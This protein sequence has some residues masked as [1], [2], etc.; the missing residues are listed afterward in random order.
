ML[1]EQTGATMRRFTL[2]PTPSLI[3]HTAFRRRAASALMVTLCLTMLVSVGVLLMARTFV[4]QNRLNMRRRELWRAFNHAEAGIASIQHWA[5]NPND[6]TLD[7][8]LF[9]VDQGGVEGAEGTGLI[10]ATGEFDT[11]YPQLYNAIH[12]AGPDG[13]EIT[14]A[15]L[16]QMNEGRFSTSD[17]RQL[18]RIERIRLVAPSA[19]DPVVSDFKI[20]ST[21]V[22]VQGVRREVLAYATLSPVMAIKIPAALI[23]YKN[24][25]VNGNAKIHWG[26]AWAKG[27][28]SM[29]SQNQ[30]GYLSTDPAA[31]WR[32]EGLINSWGGGWRVGGAN[33][34]INPAMMFPNTMG[35]KNPWRMSADQTNGHFYQGVPTGSFPNGGWPQ[36]EYTTFKQLALEHGRYYS[37]DAAGNIYRNGVETASNR[38]DFMT[39]FGHTDPNSV[40]YDL[41]FID[42]V[43]GS[44]T[45]DAPP[46]ADGSNLA[47]IDPGPSGDKG[48]K[49]I[50]YVGANFNANGT[51]NPPTISAEDPEGNSASLNQI[52]L[53]GV[54]IA[55]GWVE[56]GGNRG[57]YGS[58]IAM[59]GWKGSG[60]PNVYYDN[61]LQN[62][63]NM[64][65]GNAGSPFRITLE[66][67]Y[68]LAQG[69]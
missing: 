45:V 56:M 20:F 59:G 8:S 29:E 69:S 22:T 28:I 41:I 65:N 60:T 50:L 53:D 33:P 23:S 16:D 9:T 58:A 1:C 55:A 68:G 7:T 14:E 31:I 17:N 48:L 62:G 34:D 30:Y 25:A 19:A 46:A 26:E 15:M 18:G 36:F 42:T 5:L 44:P 21:G 2:L 51:G 4:D 6:F 43:N 10:S 38:I 52:F 27:N 61:T 57:I 11:A 12:S 39:E 47:T 24:L 37:T 40:P 63:V 3:L 54:M 64:G 67:N 13:F 66:N 32:T 49:A 35:V